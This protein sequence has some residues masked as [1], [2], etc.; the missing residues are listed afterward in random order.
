[1]DHTNKLKSKGGTLYYPVIFRIFDL[2]LKDTIA[3][4]VELESPI[5]LKVMNHEPRLK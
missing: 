5:S 4:P 3:H 2:T 1:M